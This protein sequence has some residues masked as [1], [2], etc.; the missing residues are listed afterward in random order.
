MIDSFASKQALT[1][2]LQII[3]TKEKICI[4][5]VYA[6]HTVRERLACLNQLENFLRPLDFKLKILAGDFNMILNLDEKRGGIRRLDLGSQAFQSM[7]DNLNLIDIPTKNGIHTWN[8]RRGGT[9]QI[10]SR[11]DRFLLSEDLYLSSLETEVVI[12]PQVGS[13]HWPIVLTF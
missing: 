5:N 8:N 1:T 13:D 4:T 9:R 10:A 7:I 11:L 6:P 2:I 3:G 12:A